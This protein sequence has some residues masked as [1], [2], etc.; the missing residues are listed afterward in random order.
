MRAATS[1][2]V[3]D[4]RAVTGGELMS[5]ATVRPLLA[6]ATASSSGSCRR[7]YDRPPAG[8]ARP[9]APPAHEGS[10]AGNTKIT[11]PRSAGHDGAPS[12]A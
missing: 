1:A 5:S 2:T 8:A 6:S 7:V 12:C 9:P 3:W 4:G 10:G 11:G